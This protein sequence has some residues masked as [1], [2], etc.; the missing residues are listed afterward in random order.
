MKRLDIEGNPTMVRLAE[1]MLFE[2][3]QCVF[4]LHPG[5]LAK[6]LANSAIQEN[7]NPLDFAI[8]TRGLVAE[9]FDYV[10]NITACWINGQM[11]EDNWV[12]RHAHSKTIRR[13]FSLCPLKMKQAYPKYAEEIGVDVQDFIRSLR[14]IVPRVIDWTFDEV[15]KILRGESAE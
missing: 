4:R 2:R 3:I 15:E 12:Q 13:T 9:E 11:I 8:E 10:L 7:K 1:R 14:V 6:G 5:S